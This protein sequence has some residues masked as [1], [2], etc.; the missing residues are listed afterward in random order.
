MV[1]IGLLVFI[2]AL[3]AINI[4]ATY[5]ARIS[6]DEPQYLLTAISLGEDASLDISDEIAEERFRSWH[7]IDLLAQSIVAEDTGRRISPHDPLLPLYLALPV[8]L[9]GWVGAR[10]AMAA[11][12]GLAAAL[13]FFLAERRVK[14]SPTVAFAVTLG[15][16]VTPPLITYGNQIY[17]AMAATVAVLAGVVAVTS[18]NHRYWWVTCVSICALPWLSVKYAPLAAVLFL[19]LMWQFRETRVRD[20]CIAATMVA[21]GIAYL[22]F[23]REVYGGWT[24]YASGDHF[25]DSEFD[26]VGI[27]VNPLGRTRRLVGLLVD[28]GFGLVAWAPA[29]LGAPLALTSYIKARRE[30]WVLLVALTAVTW[31][32]ATWV[33]LTM[34]GWW[35]PGRQVVPALPL[36]AVAVAAAADRSTSVLRLTLSACFV[37]FVSWLW[38]VWETSTGRRALIVDFQ[39]T[40][41]PMYSVWRHLLPD[42]Q[43]LALESPILTAVWTALLVGA[44]ALVWM[45]TAVPSSREQVSVDE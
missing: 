39:D 9:G 7:E 32:M 43:S 5:G 4:R 31:A 37:S 17:P 13:T 6:V 45:R 20:A 19:A 22:V 33:A 27:N 29:Y 18:P 36:L 21:A 11:L 35:W 2:V 14:V 8:R 28:R 16:F 3:F 12:A 44:C 25:V 40:S 1:V 42:H 10:L 38:L 26:V 23:H 34:H 15:F 24:V 30:S 41:N